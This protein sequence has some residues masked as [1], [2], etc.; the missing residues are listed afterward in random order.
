MF[1]SSN[2]V[3]VYVCIL[4]ACVYV[5]VHVLF[6]CVYKYYV[7]VNVCEYVCCIIYACVC[8]FV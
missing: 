4:G 3:C 8:T 6:A 7:G 2:Y 5:R 1:I